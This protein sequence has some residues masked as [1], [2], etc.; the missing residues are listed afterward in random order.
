MGSVRETN[1]MHPTGNITPGRYHVTKEGLLFCETVESLKRLMRSVACLAPVQTWKTNFLILKP[2]HSPIRLPK[3]LHH[4][5]QH[6][7]MRFRMTLLPSLVRQVPELVVFV[8]EKN[9]S[10][11]GLDVERGGGVFDC[12]VD[13]F[14]NT[15][16]GDGWCWGLGEFVAGDAGLG[17]FEQLVGSWW[18][19]HGCGSGDLWGVFCGE[20][21]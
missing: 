10:T 8:S 4:L 7:L 12:V 20:R 13:D 9:N 11:S 5:P 2:K 18:G 19:G 3:S 17:C 15:G 14:K 21:S 16:V 6:L 1:L